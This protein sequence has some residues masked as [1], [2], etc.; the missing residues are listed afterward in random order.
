MGEYTGVDILLY[1]V[2][3]FGGV[4]LIASAASSAKK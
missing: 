2:L 4:F 1:L 3:L